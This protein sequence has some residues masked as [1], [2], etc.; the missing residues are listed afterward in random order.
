MVDSSATGSATAVMSHFNYL[1]FEKC[2][3]F[4]V[5][6]AL[7]FL[8]PAPQ[9]LP[10]LFARCRALPGALTSTFTVY[11]RERYTFGQ[12]FDQVDA[13]AASLSA[14]FGVGRGDRCECAPYACCLLIIRCG[15]RPRSRPAS[16]LT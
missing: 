16:R 15:S 13:L 8:P 4:L 2:V 3:L 5:V 11:E 6:C 14:S 10:E 1:V 12:F 9:T 7:S